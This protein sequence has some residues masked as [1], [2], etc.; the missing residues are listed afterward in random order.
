[1]GDKWRAAWIAA[2]LVVATALLVGRAVLAE[3]HTIDDLFIFLRYARSLAEHGE[4]AFNRGERVEG[5]SSV[6]WTIAL[7]LLWRTGWRGAGT[8]KAASLV[9]A[10]CIP[11]VTWLAIR[12]A[13]PGKPLVAMVA[14]F[15]LALDA[16]LAAWASS[17][18][19]TSA[20]A[21]ACIGCVAIAATGRDRTT[22]CALGVL[23][24]IRPEGPLF[25]AAGLLGSSRGA[26]DGFRRCLWAAA[27]LAALTLLRVAYF[28]DV[29]PNTFWAKMNAVDGKDYTGLGYLANAVVRRPLLLLAAPLFAWLLVR[30]RPVVRLVLALFAASLLFPAVAGGDWMPNRRLLVVSLP[31]GALLAACS[32]DTVRSSAVTAIVSVGLLVEPALTFDHAVDQTWRDNE[33]VD[34]RVAHWRPAGRPFVDPYPLDWMPTHFLGELAPY[35]GPGDVVAHV[36]VGELPYVMLDVGFLDG[37]GLVDRTAGRLA[38]FPRDAALRDA[39]RREFFD[40]RPAAAIVVFDESAGH[41]F[42]T[43]QRVVLEDPR[44]AAGWR[45]LARVPTWGNH[46]CVTYVRRDA[47]RVGDEIARERRERWLARVPDV[48]SVP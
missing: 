43:S 28:H 8:A 9:V 32:L 45:E 21:L 40:A 35:V 6:A 19:D 4:Y 17:G 34:E 41:P 18:M 46:P 5:T 23:A 44:F 14:V 7:A 16:D 29:V 2:G 33:W 27:A 48:A 26:R 24:W 12:S 11:G 38:F 31:L 10:A 37:F 36:D 13:A 42:S 20:W 3:R 15:A 39:A 22:A 25:T 47:R 30:R 1:M